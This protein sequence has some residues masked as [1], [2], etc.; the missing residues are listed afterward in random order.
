[1]KMQFLINQSRVAKGI[2]CV[3]R[4]WSLKDN[5]PLTKDVDSGKYGSLIPLD[6]DV[7]QEVVCI[8]LIVLILGTLT[9]SMQNLHLV[10]KTEKHQIV[11]IPCCY[12]SWC[13]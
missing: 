1:M 3:S 13:W 10:S 11:N 8:N 6:A 5:M 12:K 9:V 4:Y 7:V 2:I